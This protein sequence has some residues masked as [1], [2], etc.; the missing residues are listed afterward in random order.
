MTEA[1]SED[2]AELAV[3]TRDRSPALPVYGPDGILAGIAS[4]VVALVEPDEVL[5]DGLGKNYLVADVSLFI[6]ANDVEGRALRPCVRD[7][8]GN[9]SAFRLNKSPIDNRATKISV[10]ALFEI[11]YRTLVAKY[12]VAVVPKMRGSKRTKTIRIHDDRV[13]E[14]IGKMD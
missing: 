6:D 4:N 5:G 11:E 1:T 9:L 7:D 3:K 8:E 14:I 12:R 10:A 13:A 2:F